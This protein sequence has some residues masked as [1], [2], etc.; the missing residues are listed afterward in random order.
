[1]SLFLFL[2]LQAILIPQLPDP[3]A[4]VNV[5]GEIVGPY[6]FREDVGQTVKVI[7]KN[8][9]TVIVREN[10]AVPLTSITTHVKV[11]Y[12]DEPDRLLGISHLIEHMFFKGTARR[13]VG[14]I[15]KETKALGGALN[16]YTYYDRTVYQTVVPA[17]NAVAAMEI[18]ADA[19]WNPTFDA[20][21]LAREVE[22]VLQENNQNMDTPP[23][24][25]RERLYATAFSE[26]RMRRW[27][28]GSA[29]SLRRLGR[30]DLVDYHRKYYQPSNAILSIVGRFER[31]D[32][33]EEVVRLYGDAADTALQRDVGSSE[34]PQSAIRYN[35][36]RGPI[37]QSHIAMGYH[38]PGALSGDAYVLEVLSAI[39]T[40]GRASRMNRFLRDERGV[41]HSVSSSFMGFRGLGYFQLSLGTSSPLEAEAAA[42]EEI[43]RI[44]RFGVRDEPLARAKT[45][46]AQ[47]YYHRLETVESLADELALQEALGDW[48]RINTYLNGI[49][50]VTRDDIGRVAR[51]YLTTENLSVFEYLPRSVTRTFST[52]DFRA[53]VVARIPPNM[54]ERSI[55]ELP[56]SASV[57]LPEDDLVVDLVKSPER[58]RILRGPDVYVLEDHRLPLVSFG[59]FYPGGRLYESEANSGIT[60]LML[61]SA[62]RGTRRYNTA[63]ISRRLE[64][65]GAWIEVV[66]EADFFGYVLDGVS[67]QIEEA[68][69]ILM[70]VLQEPT[71]FENGVERE[72]ILQEARIRQ[73][74]EDNL[75]YPVQLF[76][77]TSF[78]DHSYAR[79]AVGLEESLG[80]LTPDDLVEWHKLHERTLVPVIVIVGDTSG[81]GLVASISET[82]T[83]EDLFEGDIAKLRPPE[84]GLEREERIEMA[85]RRQSALVYGTIGPSFADPDRFPLT[86]IENL[87][88]GR[89]GRLFEKIREE[90]G[91]AY[92]VRVFDDFMARSGAFFTYTAFSPGNEDRVR[93]SLEDEIE[94]LI[95]DGIT[96]E[97]LETA[98][99]YSVGVH[100]IGLQTR[101]GQTLALA[102]ALMVGGGVSALTEYSAAIREVNKELV[103]ATAEKYLSPSFAKIVVL[104]G[105]Q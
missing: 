70:E 54:V 84:A 29:Q 8:G 41:I 101:R 14:Q 33:L 64:N 98:I 39:L 10:N 3:D 17:Q 19:L 79:P 18:Q 58:H 100:E 34:P 59:I 62:L 105:T 24:V 21:E 16:A 40:G 92:T 67:G 52:S 30:E 11:G 61:R 78:D 57:Q 32:L 81:T 103:Q 85:D 91:L 44:K 28:I 66:N 72:R 4:I 2:F 53:N 6:I 68:L 71:F 87:L 99:N 90:Q 65:A 89:G 47:Q 26:H 46:V 15:A 69:E 5:G 104:R 12:F 9:L 88:S 96:D 73:L 36:E 27:P 35:W 48:K 49:Q 45:F 22:V 95:E 56:V 93:A 80:A 55:E 76:M 25:S 51:L 83:N 37:E 63:D 42:L 74:R 23:A 97:E 75:R 86:V 94:R 1:M 20:G 60:E 7:L 43:E 50:E 82:L 38:V 31:E 13:G 77:S 102:R